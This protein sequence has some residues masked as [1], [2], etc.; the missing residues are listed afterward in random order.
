M[1]RRGLIEFQTDA[2]SCDAAAQKIYDAFRSWFHLFEQ[3]VKL[4]TPQR[5]SGAHVVSESP[6]PIRLFVEESNQLRPV[7]T[8]REMRINIY[9]SWKDESLHLDKL[10]E[11]CRLS[12]LG[13]H[14]RLEHQ[15]MLEAYSARN[16]ADFRKAIIEAATA[17]EVVLT[18]RA[19]EEFRIRDIS[20]GNAL[21]KK[22]RALGGRLEL[23][24]VLEIQFPDKD[25]KYVDL[26]V[27]PRNEVIHTGQSPAEP[28]VNQV[29]TE[30]ERLVRWFSPQVH[31]DEN[32]S[33]T[34]AK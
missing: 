28:L 8:N 34:G 32:R 26:I 33:Q 20:F 24:K 7:S 19:L 25:K 17:L 4:F 30:V 1:I 6:G 9:M 10:K 27:N 18:N 11:A 15:L 3:Y 16:N 2:D 31:Q 29:I 5:T 23:V 22:F 13:L 21:L 12:S 14:P